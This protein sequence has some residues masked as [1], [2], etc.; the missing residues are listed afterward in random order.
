L[1]LKLILENLLSFARQHYHLE[2]G[3]DGSESYVAEDG[4]YYE[5]AVAI[6]KDE[7]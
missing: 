7:S 4:T 3:A 5:E 1:D 6:Q 2:A